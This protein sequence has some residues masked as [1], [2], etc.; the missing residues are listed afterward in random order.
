MRSSLALSLVI[1]SFAACSSDG[2]GTPDGGDDGGD[3]GVIIGGCDS[4][5]LPTQDSCVIGD[6]FGIFVSSSLGSAS[7][8]G[9]KAKPYASLNAGIAAAKAAK[10]RVYACAEPYAESVTLADGAS[11]FGYFD[12]STAWS[13][14]NNHAK[15]QSP[16]S[17]AA[18][19]TN[20]SSATRVEAVDLVAPDFTDKSQSSIALLASASP[21]LTIA[22]ATLHAGTGGKGDDGVA[23]IQLSDS[24]TT[25]NGGDSWAKGYCSGTLCSAP[26]GGA[27]GGKNTCTN[28]S[29][30]D[31][32]PGG[33]GG[34][35]GHYISQTDSGGIT[36]HWYPDNQYPT[37]GGSPT[38]GTAQTAQGGVLGPNQ[39]GTTGSDGSNGPSGVNGAAVGTLS[40]T[41]YASS[42]GTAGGDGQPGQGGGGAGAVG[43]ALTNDP[44]I[45][46]QLHPGANG[47][48]ESG[49][50]GGAGGCPGLAGTLGKGGGASVG[51]IAIQS[52]IT[53]DT[54]KIEATN[55]G[56][57]GASG[58]PSDPTPGGSGGAHGKYTGIPGA[59]GY[60]GQGGV[61]GNGGGGPSI[62]IAAQGAPPTLKS[63]TIAQGSGGAGVPQ[64]TATSLIIPASPDGLSKDVYSF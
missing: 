38:T 63:S 49:G 50:G 6:T 61:S 11:V 29:G 53:L 33:T 27:N 45:N 47:W 5:K 25:K 19:A 46:P 3:G 64:R 39:P 40:A 44:D 30:H 35:A 58:K 14:G 60:G 51:I 24:G 55:G 13:I 21:G 26:Y 43:L 59:G 57:A 52:P 36:Y 10:K 56:A 54:V 32:Y 18:T 34:A 17:P 37:T 20:I 12:C 16:T 42:D 1:I 2:G 8:D 9:T 48:G 22:N 62:G 15:V 28:A 31:G 7:G 41:G 23:G 4:T